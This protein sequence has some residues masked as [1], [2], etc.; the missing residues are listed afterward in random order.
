MELTDKLLKGDAHNLF[1]VVGIFIAVVII[2]GIS[3]LFIPPAAT[4]IGGL[5]QTP[6]VAQP[7]FTCGNLVY[8][9]TGISFSLG[10]NQNITYY[11]N[12][13][14]VASESQPLS[15]S[16]IPINFSVLNSDQIG[17]LP[18]GKSA[19]VKFSDFAAGG[20]PSN[21]TSSTVFI[22]YVWLG[23][24]TTICTSPTNYTKVATIQLSSGAG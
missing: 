4:N 12:W 23:Y 24:C 7:G 9:T 20:I 11:G 2:I 8:T 18:S 6:C 22:G 5:R 10:Q 21:P 16:N 1:I 14:F 3:N 15:S 13:V 19:I 17:T